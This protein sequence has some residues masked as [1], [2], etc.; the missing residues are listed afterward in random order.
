MTRTNSSSFVTPPP[1]AWLA[2]A[3]WKSQREEQGVSPA[4]DSPTGLESNRS[5]RP[6]ES[7]Q[8]T[9]RPRASLCCKVAVATGVV[10]ASLGGMGLVFGMA[11]GLDHLT[12]PGGEGR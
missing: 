12:G 11:Y 5:M 2:G 3:C 4:A 1:K 9:G 10:A 8:E 7:G 6:V